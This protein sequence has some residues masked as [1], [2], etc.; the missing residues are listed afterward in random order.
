MK[1]PASPKTHPF[2][3]L[4]QWIATPLDYLEGTQ[5]VYGDCFT[6]RFGGL[7]PMVMLSNPQGIQQLLTADSKQFDSGRGSQ[8]LRPLVGDNSMLLLD[9]DRHQRDRQLLT[10]PFHG[11]RMRTYGNMICDISDKVM[12]KR[13]IGEP[14]FVRAAMQ[15]ISLLAILNAVFGVSRG[16]RFEKLKE[17]LTSMLDS[18]S[19]PLSSSVLFFN[20][21]QRDFG[22]WSPW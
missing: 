19:S 15:E 17:L 16:E 8:I 1:L 13:M 6:A 21:L 18:V 14:F 20:S 10:P 4:L 2:A 5:K 22:A 9:G 12:S 3:Q 11:E 7:P